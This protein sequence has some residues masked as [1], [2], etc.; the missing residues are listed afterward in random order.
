V[1]TQ[2]ALFEV[3]DRAVWRQLPEEAREELGELLAGVLLKYVAQVEGQ[4]APRS[5]VRDDR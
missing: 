2:L 5:E 3:V 4:F 1:E